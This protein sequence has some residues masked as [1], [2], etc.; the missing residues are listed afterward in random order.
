MFWKQQQNRSF[1]S[2]PAHVEHLQ[3]ASCLPDHGMKE[4]CVGQQGPVGP[5]HTGACV[6]P[7]LCMGWGYGGE[8]ENTGESAESCTVEG[9][10]TALCCMITNPTVFTFDICVLY[11]FDSVG[12]H[13]IPEEN[14]SCRR[15][16]CSL[17]SSQVVKNTGRWTTSVTFCRSFIPPDGVAASGSLSCTGTLKLILSSLSQ[18]IH[19]L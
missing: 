4:A 6:C 19:I 12:V 15:R 7:R 5:G 14:T 9:V 11:I 18:L 17:V 1:P 13:I 3:G 10:I 16:V 2:D 8:L